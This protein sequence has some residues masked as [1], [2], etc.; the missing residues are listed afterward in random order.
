MVSPLAAVL[1]ASTLLPSTLAFVNTAPFVLWSQ[2]SLS[3]VGALSSQV[4]LEGAVV[5]SPLAYDVLS[6]E[7]LCSLGGV[8]V[9]DQEGLHASDLPSMSFL[10]RLLP[11]A[12]LQLP[13][14][15]S[16]SP[17]NLDDSLAQ[18]AKACGSV[19]QT[20]QAGEHI[21]Q[22][23]TSVVQIVKVEGKAVVEEERDAD[24]Q[25]EDALISPQIISFLDTHASSHLIVL[26]GHPSSSSSPLAIQQHRR[27]QKEVPLLLVSPA[28]AAAKTSSLPSKNRNGT[29]VVEN[30]LPLLARYQ[31]LST[32]ILTCLIVSFGLLL[33]ILAFGI[34][35]LQSIKVPER[36]TATKGIIVTGEKKNQ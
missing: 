12:S 25:W 19:V 20:V 7:S 36:M 1:V 5:D 22:G 15:T 26:T 3:A 14:L 16:T 9:I 18:L 8:L 10:S 11:S 30:D 29:T 17:S 35:A 13:Y 27:N 4:E 31:I 24:I 33:P 21:P 34:S 23:E 2:P 28:A 32:P 6:D